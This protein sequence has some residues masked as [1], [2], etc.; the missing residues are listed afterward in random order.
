MVVKT[1]SQLPKVT[2][3]G[4]V[5]SNDLLEISE[6]NDA[7]LF[8]SK[9]VY[10]SALSGCISNATEKQI[11]NAY[12]LTKSD[13]TKLS[14]RT[15]DTKVNQ[16]AGQQFTFDGIKQFKNWSWISADYPT[17]TSTA[18][19]NILDDYFIPN[20]KK[21]KQMIGTQPVYFST[22][23]SQVAEGN[24]L[25]AQG[26]ATVDSSV[27]VS[28]SYG[29]TI[30]SG[31]F[32][33]WHIDEKDSSEAVYDDKSLSRD[34]YELIRDTGQLVV[35][36]WLADKGDVPPEM[37]WVGLFAALKCDGYDETQKFD[38]PIAV[39]PWV[40]GEYASTLQYIGFTVPVK[41]GLKLKI[42]TGFPV[43]NEN[44]GFQNA[45]T[46]TFIDMNIPNSF[47]G[48]VVK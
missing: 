48:Y 19:Q 36:G 28:L 33:F 40:R 22:D 3:A 13:G 8:S 5:K 35:W 39:Q 6:P 14:V 7:G 23:D 44:S 16:I 41:E 37:A 46:M 34:K 1:I 30:G 21:V 25:P 18:Y 47:F 27:P 12:L 38:I 20:V 26:N 24:P 43:N 9:A 17:N 4:S 42:K 11:A 29:Q 15:I 2:A 32:Y 10:L 45:G 31:K